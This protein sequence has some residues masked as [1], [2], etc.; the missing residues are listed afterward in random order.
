MT[1]SA[2]I[3]GFRRRGLRASAALALAAPLSACAA[4]GAPSLIVAGSYFPLWMAFAALGIA[5]ALAL[6]LA[7][8]RAKLDRAIAFPLA[9][10]TALA[11]LISSAL[12]LF[13]TGGA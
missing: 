4:N 8:G 2:A 7:L 5:A 10:Y 1:R 6:R 13:R 3:A 12:W 11:L 9:F